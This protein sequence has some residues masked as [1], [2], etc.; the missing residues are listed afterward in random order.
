MWRLMSRRE[1]LA[2]GLLSAPV[3]VGCGGGPGAGPPLDKDLARSS[4]EKAL[5]AWVDGKKP[6]EL[7][8]EITIGDFEWEGGKTKLVS[9]R[10]LT[11]KER[12][13]GSSLHVTVLREFRNAQGKVSK[14]EAIYVV[15]TSPVITIFPQ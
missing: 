11:D 5:Q 4:V 14:S 10:L 9:F 12:T 8:P 1:W 15:G 2:R 13:D 7:K 6:E 3:L